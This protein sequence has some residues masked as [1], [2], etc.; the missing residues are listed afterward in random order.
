MLFQ[1]PSVKVGRIDKSLPDAKSVVQQLEVARNKSSVP[2][3]SQL[4]LRI[5][6]QGAYPFPRTEA[7][8]LS[9]R[10]GVVDSAGY[11]D[12]EV[13]QSAL[14]SESLQGNITSVLNGTL[15]HTHR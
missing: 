10:P 11:Q 4:S 8:N 6:V 7:D 3:Y 13:L 1:I 15:V 12:E 9:A 14:D 2:P 5:R